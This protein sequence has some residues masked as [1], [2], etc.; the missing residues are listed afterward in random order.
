M[1]DMIH[2]LT[3]KRDPAFALTPT[4]E[5]VHCFQIPVNLLDCNID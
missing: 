4:C 2:A 3:L 5:C 1:Y